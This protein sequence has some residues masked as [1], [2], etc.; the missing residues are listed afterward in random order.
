MGIIKSWIKIVEF[1]CNIY[2]YC[3]VDLVCK[4]CDMII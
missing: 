4:L 1:V 3:Y 2:I